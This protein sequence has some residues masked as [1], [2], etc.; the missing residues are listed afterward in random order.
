[1]KAAQRLALSRENG[2]RECVDLL[3]QILNQVLD[4]GNSITNLLVP[5]R[6][7]LLG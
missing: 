7:Q 4:P 2:S 6:G 5:R 3:S 1:M